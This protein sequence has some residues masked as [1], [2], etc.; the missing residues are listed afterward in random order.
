MGSFKLWVSGAAETR[1]L[2]AGELDVPGNGEFVKYR[3][4]HGR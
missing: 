4:G 2:A 3:F 1:R